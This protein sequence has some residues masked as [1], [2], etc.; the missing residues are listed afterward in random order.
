MLRFIRQTSFQPFRV[1]RSIWR[2][3]AGRGYRVAFYMKSGNKVSVDLANFNFT[4]KDC[5]PTKMDWRHAPLAKDIL[6]YIDLTQVE[7]IVMED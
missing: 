4:S 1:L 2:A 3:L 5:V 6:K 7:S